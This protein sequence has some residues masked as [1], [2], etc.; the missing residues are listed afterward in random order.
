MVINGWRDKYNC[1]QYSF[2]FINCLDLKFSTLLLSSFSSSVYSSF[3][4]FAQVVNSIVMNHVTIGDGCSIQGSVICSNV[5]LQERAV[6]KDCQVRFSLFLSF[7]YHLQLLSYYYYIALHPRLAQA[8][9][10]LLATSSKG[11]SWL[12]KRNDQ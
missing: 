9:W 8:L 6:L 5:Q 2:S 10:S 3:S 7:L 11:R 12:R 4:S 1:F